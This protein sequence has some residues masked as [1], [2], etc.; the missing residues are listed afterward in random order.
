MLG[1]SQEGSLKAEGQNP[2]TQGSLW[3]NIFFV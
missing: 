1:K 3:K 2:M